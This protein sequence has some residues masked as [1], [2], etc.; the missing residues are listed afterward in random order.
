VTNT[1]RDKLKAALAAKVRAAAN[2]LLLGR[3]TWDDTVQ[4]DG[5]AVEIYHFCRH[6]EYD[7]DTLVFGDAD[8]FQ[9]MSDIREVFATAVAD[10]KFKHYISWGWHSYYQFVLIKE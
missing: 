8:V 4:V 2:D 3:T 7:I 5:E 1:E 10:A 9:M 6:F